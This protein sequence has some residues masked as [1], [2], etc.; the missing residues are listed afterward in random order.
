MRSGCLFC[1]EKHLQQAQI[2]S[3]EVRKG[4]SDHMRYVCGHMA[5]A[6]DHLLEAYPDMANRIR[7]Y[8]LEYRNSFLDDRTV[9]IPFDDVLS[10]IEELIRIEREARHEHE[11]ANE[12]GAQRESAGV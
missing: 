10:T 4:H 8:R 1:A 2:I 5:E 11:T 12:D 6:E 9:T 7:D 3:M